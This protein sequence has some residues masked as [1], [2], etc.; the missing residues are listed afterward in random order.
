MVSILLIVPIPST[1]VEL[2]LI[3]IFIHN[4]VCV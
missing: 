1:D 2:E 3:S 4:F